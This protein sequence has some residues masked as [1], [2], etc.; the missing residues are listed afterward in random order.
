MKTS[1]WELSQEI[2]NKL[3][4]ADSIVLQMVLQKLDIGVATK[5]CVVKSD[6]LLCDPVIWVE[7]DLKNVTLEQWNDTRAYKTLGNQL[8]AEGHELRVNLESMC[9]E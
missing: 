3:Q 4:D 2:A 5:Y 8:I 9:E 1:N 7:K 6:K